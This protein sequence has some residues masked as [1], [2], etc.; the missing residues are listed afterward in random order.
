MSAGEA[1]PPRS[2]GPLPPSY[3]RV[4]DMEMRR[5]RLM[6]YD[7]MTVEADGKPEQI[8]VYRGLYGHVL[9]VR[10]GGFPSTPM[11]ETYS[12]LPEPLAARGRHPQRAVGTPM[13]P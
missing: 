9:A 2:A 11:M 13:R 4:F 7:R 3:E 6:T 1:E 5:L 10:P 8:W 12:I